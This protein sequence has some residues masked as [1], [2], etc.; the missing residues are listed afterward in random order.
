MISL[1][2][3][4][5]QKQSLEELKCKSFSIS[6]PLPDHPDLE[7]C[8]SPIHFMSEDR[9][10]GLLSQRPTTECQECVQRRHHSSLGLHLP[11]LSR[12]NS[13]HLRGPSCTPATDTTSTP[14]APP[15][16]RHC[17]S[18]SVPEDLSRWRPIWRPTSSK[19][20]TPVK[21]RCNSGG[22][23]GGLTVQAHSPTP[24]ATNLRFHNDPSASFRCIQACS[25][26][27]FSLAFCRESPGSCTLSPIGAFSDGAEGPNCFSLQRRF[28]LSPVLFKDTGQFLPSAS[29]S[30]SYTPELV[31]RQHCL[32]RSQSQPCDL[33]T[34]K[35]GTKRRHEEDV[36]WHRPSL[37]F[38]KMNQKQNVGTLC[39]F[40]NSDERSSSSSFLACTGMSPCPSSSPITSC[41]HVLSEEE[42]IR[43]ERITSTHS[44]LFQ[45]D[46]A[47]LDLNL[48]EEN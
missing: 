19:V 43:R 29:S 47:D 13:P 36:R 3:E 4:Q 22:G 2:T 26:P 45:Q 15:S 48:I 32:P 46:F 30:P 38:Y 23:G 44:R 11:L 14:P 39:F 25:P 20:W 33:N 12:E 37:D 5:L 1:I 6:L 34:R 31:R 10:W 18:L 41:I 24:Q 9:S 21:R 35:C 16:K 28:S 40:D 42:E 17:R 7:G 27:F 8:S